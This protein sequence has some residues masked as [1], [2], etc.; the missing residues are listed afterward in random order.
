MPHV[1]PQCSRMPGSSLCRAD[2]SKPKWPLFVSEVGCTWSRR[3][4][5]LTGSAK[6]DFCVQAACTLLEQDLCL[7]SFLDVLSGMWGHSEHHLRRMCASL[8]FCDGWSQS[9]GLRIHFTISRG[10]NWFK[11]ISLLTGFS[12]SGDVVYRII[13]LFHMIMCLFCN[14]PSDNCVWFTL[15]VSTFS[16]PWKVKQGQTAFQLCSSCPYL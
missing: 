1:V 8:G 11:K 14:K 12:K 4:S 7:A 3:C 16:K 9:H 5:S 6:I 2:R 10:I 13:N 15:L